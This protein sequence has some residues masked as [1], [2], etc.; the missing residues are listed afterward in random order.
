M[1]QDAAQR[2]GIVERLG[3][4]RRG[5]DQDRSSYATRARATDFLEQEHL[6]ATA[7]SGGLHRLG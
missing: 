7:K 3:E 5:K 6:G 1:R 2:G 4:H